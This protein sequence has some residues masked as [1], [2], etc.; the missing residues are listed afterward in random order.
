[1]CESPF[2]THEEVLAVIG[3]ASHDPYSLDAEVHH[4]TDQA[5]DVGRIV[6]AVR[7]GLAL[8]RMAYVIYLVGNLNLVVGCL[9]PTN[10]IKEVSVIF[11]SERK[12]CNR[13]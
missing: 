12:L 9:A 5:H 13:Y 10:G 6:F 3:K 8:I 1:M 2:W 11:G 7:V 4:L